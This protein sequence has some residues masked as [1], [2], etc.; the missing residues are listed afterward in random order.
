MW[1]LGELSWE[2]KDL[3]F[4]DVEDFKADIFEWFVFFFLIFWGFGS[5]C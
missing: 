4:E 3:K 5:F 1:T 2:K